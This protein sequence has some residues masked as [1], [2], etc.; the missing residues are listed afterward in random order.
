MKITQGLNPWHAKDLTTLFL[1]TFK[2]DEKSS[3]WCGNAICYDKM[4]KFIENQAIKLPRKL[5]SKSFLA[6]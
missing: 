3:T 2:I 1:F 6:G 5:L 4:D